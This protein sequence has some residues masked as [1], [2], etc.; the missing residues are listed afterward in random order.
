MGKDI[1]LR[2]VKTIF[3]AASAFFCE[4]LDKT[5]S[6]EKGSLPLFSQHSKAEVL[7]TPKAPTSKAAQKGEK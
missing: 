7:L 5:F 3:L 1:Y 6:R 4:L 2:E